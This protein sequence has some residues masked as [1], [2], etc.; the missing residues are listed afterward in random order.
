MDFFGNQKNDFPNKLFANLGIQPERSE[1]LTKI[2]LGW[3]D[4]FKSYHHQNNS[5][6]I[7]SIMMLFY[8][9]FH[10]VFNHLYCLC[11]IF[12]KPW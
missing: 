7:F 6:V 10:N 11:I 1:A 8:K 3:G 2:L 4:Q 12:I 5:S 9:L